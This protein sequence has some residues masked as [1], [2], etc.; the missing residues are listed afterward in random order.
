MSKSE[1]NPVN[2]KTACVELGRPGKPWSSSRMSAIKKAMGLTHVRYF[3]LSAVR[4]F[5]RT[6]PTFRERDVYASRRSS[7][8]RPGNRPGPRLVTAGKP[9][10]LRRSNGR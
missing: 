1:E 3:F 5:L 9:G 8:K 4:E 6:N 7:P 2:A 10:A